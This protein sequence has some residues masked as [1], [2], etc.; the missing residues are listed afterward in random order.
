MECTICGHK[1]EEG[2]RYCAKCGVL[3]SQNES[4]NTV[5]PQQNEFANT[6]TP[7]RNESA[8]IVTPE[9]N[10][11]LYIP[12]PEQ[13][14]KPE[15]QII[16]DRPD[17]EEPHVNM[18]DDDLDDNSGKFSGFFKR[19]FTGI[20]F[21][22]ALLLGIPIIILIFTIIIFAPRS[23]KSKA[24]LKEHHIELIY[25][26]N[27]VYISVDNAAKFSVDGILYASQSNTD[28]GKAALL[29]DYDYR[30]GGTLW[31]VTSSGATRIADDVYAFHLADSGNGI[32]Y[33]TDYDPGYSTA[34]LYLYDT[35]NKKTTHITDEAFYTG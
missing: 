7:Q 30:Y 9:Q 3:L 24:N 1:N 23:G 21:K 11:P 2:S 34:L 27:E 5:T 18:L 33:F 35:S 25:D 16:D 10:E 32:V 17:I 6:V 28:G 4:A 26:G 19:F 29:T 31:F 14:P 8:N 22:K 13:K 12:S 20:T 15:P